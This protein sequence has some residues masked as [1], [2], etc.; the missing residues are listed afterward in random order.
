M[1]AEATP[2]MLM[3]T[4]YLV[5]GLSHAAYLYDVEWRRTA[6]WVARALLALH[7][8]ALVTHLT[9]AAEPFGT[10]Y[11]TTLFLAWAA[12]GAYVLVDARR[13]LRAVGAM[14]MPIL[15]ALL[16]ASAGAP[17]GAGP[18]V[19]ATG[20]PGLFWHVGLTVVSYALFAVGSLTSIAYL[21]LE[22]QLRRRE[23]R[24]LFYRL[25]SLETLDRLGAQLVGLAFPLLTLGI[26][27]GLTWARAA[28]RGDFYADPKLSWTAV[29]WLLYAGYLLARLRGY[30]G[31]R[32]AWLN[33][34]AF[35][36]VLV[37]YFVI[38]L[39]FSEWHGL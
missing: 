25:P 18:A 28:W 16:I 12:L 39:F 34:A 38:N 8:V 30:R 19:P 35:A 22:K 33:C 9:S 13:P 1:S 24:R 15:L 36:G 4:G 3:F 20:G 5:A 27:A 31:R 37:N 23:F 32:A 17:A 29:N 11:G 7:T 21:A 26:L 14:L 10:L 6:V 2:S